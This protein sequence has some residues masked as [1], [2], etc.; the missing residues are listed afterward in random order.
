M[1]ASYLYFRT[2]DGLGNPG[3]RFAGTLPRLALGVTIL[4]SNCSHQAGD[5]FPPGR[6][7][8]GVGGVR[9]TL[10]PTTEGNPGP[11]YRHLARPAR[12]HNAAQGERMGMPNSPTES[13]WCSGRRL[14]GGAVFAVVLWRVGGRSTFGPGGESANRIA[15]RMYAVN[16]LARVFS[17]NSRDATRGPGWGEGV[18]RTS[19]THYRARRC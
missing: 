5:G 9:H 16:G 14:H 18:A 11:S 8:D 6:G 7:N 12:G 19:S 2:N 3:L 1:W 15:K 4:S 10:V 17:A 13:G